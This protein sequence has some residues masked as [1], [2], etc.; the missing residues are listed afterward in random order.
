MRIGVIGGGTVGRATARTYLGFADDVLVYD[1][2]PERSTTSES[3]VLNTCDVIFVCL[4]EGEVNGFFHR[5]EIPRDAHFVIK[6]TVQVGTTRML[7]GTLGLIHTVHS[8]EFLTERCAVTDAL[9]PARNVIGDPFDDPTSEAVD[10]LQ[11]L[12]EKRFPG[13]QTLVMSS[14]ESEAVK[15][16]TNSFFAVKIAFFNEAKCL[17]E[18]YHMDWEAVLAGVLSDGRISHHHT[19]VPGPDGKYGFGGKCLPKDLKLFAG[20]MARIGEVPYLASA[21]YNRNLADRGGQQ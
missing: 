17:A 19:A 20:A 3:D 10:R 7:A 6:S 14:T 12:Y 13:V 8:P 2:L 21:A 9:L 4:P 11:Q 15:L 16:I 18:A 1:P 5:P